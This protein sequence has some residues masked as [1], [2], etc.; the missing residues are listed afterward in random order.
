MFP[1]VAFDALPSLLPSIFRLCVFNHCVTIGFIKIW[2]QILH[3]F[4]L[5][6]IF[7]GSKLTK[8]EFSKMNGCF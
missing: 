4:E 3:V 2:I 6:I 7:E 5:E 8:N 1:F